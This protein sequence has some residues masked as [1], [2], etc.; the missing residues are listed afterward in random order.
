MSNVLVTDVESAVLVNVI[1]MPRG[2]SLHG[3]PLVRLVRLNRMVMIVSKV[4]EL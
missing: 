3:P 4:E 2:L 1:I